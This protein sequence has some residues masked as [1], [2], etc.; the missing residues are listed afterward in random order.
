MYLF[1]F[2]EC[3]SMILDFRQGIV[4]Y[5]D[6]NVLYADINTQYVSV[7][8]QYSR[9]LLTFAHD[10]VD[11]LYEE[12]IDIKNAFGPFKS[13]IKY[14]LYFDLNT[15]TGLRTFGATSKQPIVSAE[16]P[17]KLDDLHWFN[18]TNNTMYVVENDQWIQ[19][20]RVFV[21][22]YYDHTVNM[23]A[24]GTQVDNYTEINAG[25]ILYDDADTPSAQ[26]REDGTYKFLTSASE[27]ITSKLATTVVSLDASFFSYTAN[28]IIEKNKL[29]GCFSAN[30]IV[31]SAYSG[32]PC[33]GI[34]EHNVDQNQKCL[35]SN[36]VYVTDDAW[37]FTETP[38]TPIYLQIDGDFATTVPVT[39]FIQKV[40]YIVSPNTVYIDTN[41]PVM[42]YDDELQSETPVAVGFNIAAG[43]INTMTKNTADE[44]STV[45]TVIYGAT[46]KQLI[47]NKKWVLNH[48]YRLQ[49]FLVQTYDEYGYIMYP[50]NITKING[51]TIEVLFATR[52]MGTAQLF[53][54]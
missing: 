45:K 3:G 50:S 28:E 33:V 54:F 26:A 6:R 22:I 36:N 39:G 25:F 13:N 21:A 48:N 44:M 12:K 37:N 47:P 51:N 19:K 10:D 46:Y 43:H 34:V 42:V 16:E 35:I 29:V 41:S 9:L 2:T 32:L 23:Y 8:A 11:Y 5:T 53:L 1:I 4:K 7:N 52:V 18:K 14:W 38:M 49:N 24:P 30:T 31:K 20:L 27:L 15:L 17:T 40:G